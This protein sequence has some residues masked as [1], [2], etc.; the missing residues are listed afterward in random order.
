MIEVMGL[1]SAVPCLR[2]QMF[3]SKTQ[4][5]ALKA[6]RDLMI[7]MTS[8]SEMF[9]IVA[10]WVHSILVNWE[11]LGSIRHR[12]YKQGIE[13]LCFFPLRFPCRLISSISVVVVCGGVPI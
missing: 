11:T 6:L 12:V 3:P 10:G 2:A 4:F 13:G 5:Y 1:A 8:G 9:S 7:F